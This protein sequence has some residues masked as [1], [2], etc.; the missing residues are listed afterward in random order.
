MNKI[1]SYALLITVVALIALS[2]ILNLFIQQNKRLKGNEKAL[3]EKAQYFESESGKSASSVYKLTLTKRELEAHNATLIEGINDLKIKLRR[4]QSA[5]QTAQ[6]SN[7][8]VKTIIKDT[9]IFRDKIVKLR[10][11]DYAD[12]WMTFK[13]T[14]DSNIFTGNIKTYDTLIQVVHRIPRKFLFFRFG[15]K[16]IRQDI[17]TRNPHSNITYTEYIELKK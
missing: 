1:L 10:K 16:A 8:D 11:I 12:A 15:T 2:I 5:S 14:I 3:I 4:V 7:Y 17:V 13:G 9:T 6:S